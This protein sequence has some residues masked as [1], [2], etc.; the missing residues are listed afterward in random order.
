MKFESFWTE[1][2]K[3]KRCA[4]KSYA[5]NRWNFII[6]TN[7]D[8][9]STRKLGWIWGDFARFGLI[10]NLWPNVGFWALALVLASQKSKKLIFLHQISVKGVTASVQNQ[11]LNPFLVQL[12]LVKVK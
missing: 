9:K 1:M 11:V 2:A 8:L 10:L 6:W 7:G 5:E 3:A 12:A 4:P